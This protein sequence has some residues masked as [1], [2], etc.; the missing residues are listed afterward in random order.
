MTAHRRHQDSDR[1]AGPEGLAAD[2]QAARRAPASSSGCA[3]QPC[4]SRSRPVCSRPRS[5]PHAESRSQFPC[6][7]AILRS[8][9]KG[10]VIG[11]IA[12]ILPMRAGLLMFVSRVRRVAAADGSM[13]T[14]RRGLLPLA[15]VPD[16][17]RRDGR[18]ERVIRR[19]HPV[20][21]VAVLPRRRHEI[22]QPIEK[23]TRREI[24]DAIGSWPRGIDIH[25]L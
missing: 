21:R 18:P 15:D 14:A 12:P 23:L 4:T 16:R 11:A 25:S 3:S 2:T 17:K 19:K 22:G 8:S 5:A 1:V 20:I 7:C 9:L 6:R 10:G 24:D 13:S